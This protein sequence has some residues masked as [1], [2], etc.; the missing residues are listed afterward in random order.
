LPPLL[1][2]DVTRLRA[3]LESRTSELGTMA[4]CANF[5]IVSE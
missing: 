4:A 3:P 5:W 2:L 1:P